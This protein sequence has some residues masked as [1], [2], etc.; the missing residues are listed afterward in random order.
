MSAAYPCY[1]FLSASVPVISQV[2]TA[3][4]RPREWRIGSLISAR[5]LCQK[6]L[7]VRVALTALTGSRLPGVPPQALKKKIAIRDVFA[8]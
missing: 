4:W 2:K 7:R 6:H 3:P 1:R 5:E 8:I